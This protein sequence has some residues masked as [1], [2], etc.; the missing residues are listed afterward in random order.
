MEAVR[1]RAMLGA[2][3]LCSGLIYE[4]QQFSEG[5]AFEDDVSIV[6]TEVNHLIKDSG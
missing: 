5:D 3:E 1:K 2:E 6:A 4:I